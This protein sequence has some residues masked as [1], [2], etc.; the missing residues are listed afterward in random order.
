M[1][2]FFSSL[3]GW[4]PK[5]FKGGGSTTVSPPSPAKAILEKQIDSIIMDNL[6][7]C[8]NMVKFN[9][10][11]V[12]WQCVYKA[13]AEAESSYD[14]YSTYFEDKLADKNG[15]DPATGM[16]YLSEGLF[17]LSY[18]DALPGYYSCDFDIAGDKGKSEKDKTKT[19][20]NVERNTK[21]AMKIMDKLVGIKG[22]FIFESGNY[23]A[24]L[25]PS[26]PGHAKYLKAFE[27][28]EKAAKENPVVEAPEV[29]IPTV[30]I[31]TT[32]PVQVEVDTP[33]T[34]PPVSETKPFGPAHPFTI[35]KIAIIVGHG[36]YDAKGNFD[37]GAQNWN[38]E[39]EF[40]Y[41]SKVA[42]MIAEYAY[43]K[44][45]KV[46]WRKGR[47]IAGV[48]KDAMAWNPDITVELHNNSFNK[49]AKGCEVLVIKK[50]HVSLKCGQDFA[51]K[52]CKEFGRVM[53]DG[54]GVKELEGSDRGAF[55]LKQVNDPPPSILLEPFFGDNKNDWMEARPYAKFLGN[56]LRDL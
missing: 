11:V 36:D 34:T 48:A 49:I 16:R 52:Y 29:Q 44:E 39:S 45:V 32:G 35:R 21:C 7:N 10:S 38:G 50:D 55:S 12:F 3:F 19:I 1:K 15:N 14:V 20:F 30:E 33:I 31:P 53:R 26:R 9:P 13:M 6:I 17:Q 47:G 24:V 54:D 37:T 25:K 51:A 5:L 42:N 2:A 8:P 43:P 40:A 46:F 18:S 41:Q 4:I 56:W 28:Y 27:A 23:W 22:N